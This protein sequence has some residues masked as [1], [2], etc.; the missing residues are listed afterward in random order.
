MSNDR[1]IACAL[2]RVSS[3]E[4]ARGGYGLEFQEQDIRTFCTR[5]NVELLRV[6]RDEGY[7]GA[8]ANRPGFQ[9]MLDWARQKRFQMLVIWKLD[10]LFRDTKLTLQT[11][12]E[13]ASLDIEVRSVQES[14]THDS[15]GRFLLTIFAAGAEKERRDIA[16]RMYSGRLASARKGTWVFGGVPFGYRYHPKRKALVID[17][18]EAKVVRQMFHWLVEQKLT[19]Y[20]LQMRINE[21]RIPTRSDRLGRK[22][23]SGT[24]G[25]WAKRTIGRILT[26][27]VYRGE[28][29][30]GSRSAVKATRLQSEGSGISIK[31]P[32]LISNSL[33]E[34]VQ[35][36]LSEN[37]ERSPRRTK[38]LYLLRGLMVCGQD[39][40]RMQAA[41]Q[42]VD[43]GRKV[44]YRYYSC[45]GTRK[46]VSAVRCPSRAV[47]ESRIA[48]P[49]W[50][51]L[52]QLLSDP[53]TVLKQITEYR[54]K[55]LGRE[56][57]EARLADFTL[58][59]QRTLERRRR[60]IELYLAQ[61]IERDIF[62]AESLKLQS[63]IR[64][65]DEELAR[66]KNMT[67]AEDAI[68]ERARTV[69]Q[70]YRRYQTKLALASDK[71]KREILTLFI[72]Q[73]TVRGDDLEIQVNLPEPDSFVGQASQRSSRKEDFPIVLRARLVSVSEIFKEK[74]MSR[75]LGHWATKRP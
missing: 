50:A 38:E 47:S 71:I 8:T 60:L 46:G 3:E 26:N 1:K 49:V 10:R 32:P 7:S 43:R 69:E 48:P 41:R 56:E 17:K 75:N 34:K 63:E 68:A 29:T 73:I 51:S 14:F 70:L 21:L 42:T 55:K 24:S 54:I 64:R 44:S 45:T 2:V 11:V 18:D 13:L 74:G 12:D 35:V 31:T 59:R 57:A 5:N 19:L 61:S 20:K 58:Q 53:A 28:V 37:R 36:Q 22:K 33:F 62:R 72:K 6:F 4:Q 16:L 15:N 52:T 67:V 25:W 40:R 9:E 27:P 66:I 65:I 39:H 30:S 23:P